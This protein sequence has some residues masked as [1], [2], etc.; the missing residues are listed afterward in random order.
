[1]SSVGVVVRPQF[2]PE[3]LRAVAEAADAGADAVILQPTSDADPIE[4]ARFAGEQVRP[5]LT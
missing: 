4:F 1:V 2:A 3:Q 5:L